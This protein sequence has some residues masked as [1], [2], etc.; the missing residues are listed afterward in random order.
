M[1]TNWKYDIF[2]KSRATKTRWH[3]LSGSRLRPALASGS[4][5]SPEGRSY[6][7]EN[8][9]DFEYVW[10]AIKPMQPLDQGNSYIIQVW[11]R[12]SRLKGLGRGI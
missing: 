12:G 11:V 9:T 2:S 8:A 1:V 3:K 6:A 5:S 7:S 10:G 4:A